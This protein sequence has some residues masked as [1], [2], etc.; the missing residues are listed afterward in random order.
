MH[1][2]ESAIHRIDYN[3]HKKQPLTL[4][5]WEIS[6]RILYSKQW[7]CGYQK[8]LL[9]KFIPF[10]QKLFCLWFIGNKTLCCPICQ[11]V[12]FLFRST[13][14]SILRKERA[15]SPLSAFPCAAMYQTHWR[16]RLKYRQLC[17]AT[18]YQRLNAQQSTKEIY[19]RIYKL[20][21]GSL[22]NQ[23]VEPCVASRRRWNIGKRNNHLLIYGILFPIKTALG[24]ELF[25]L[26]CIHCN[27]HALFWGKRVWKTLPN[28][29]KLLCCN[30]TSSACASNLPSWGLH[31]EMGLGNFVSLRCQWAFLAPFTQFDDEF[32]LCS[33]FS[34][35]LRLLLDVLITG[36]NV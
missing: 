7:L 31:C 33:F 19:P 25:L 32:F 15:I 2:T 35:C 18:S 4:K 14:S 24:I 6:T 27:P 30:S 12:F 8:P 5:F 13:V 22:R 36:C 1:S 34:I 9:K 29:P 23:M 11:E 28:F 21:V 10:S 20:N 26:K 16:Y 3:N 17:C